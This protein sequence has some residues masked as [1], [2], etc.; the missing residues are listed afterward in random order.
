MVPQVTKEYWC[1]DLDSYDPYKCNALKN[2]GHWLDPSDNVPFQEYLQNWQPPGCMLHRYNSKDVSTCFNSRKVVLVG[3][4]TVRQIY[5]AIAR[6]L[7]AKAAR[8]ALQVAGKH[9]DLVFQSHNVDIIFVWDPYLNS[10]KLH[11]ELVSYRGSFNLLENDGLNKSQIASVVVIGGG[12]WDV[13][14]TGVDPVKHFAVSIDEIVSH[15]RQHLRDKTK[16]APQS[17]ANVPVDRDL[18]LLTPVQVPL[19]EA[20]SPVRAKAITPKKVNSM[21]DYLRRASGSSGH[22]VLWSYSTM[23]WQLKAAYEEGGLHV[24]D[25][26][27]NQQADILLNLRCNAKLDALGR[28]PFDRTCCSRYPPPNQVQWILLSCGLWAFPLLSLIVG[29]GKLLKAQ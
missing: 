28:Y 8:E 19:Y 18:L 5:W 7:D 14:Y 4:S 1:V 17:S 13:R 12:L 9:V 15:T 25:S 21:N 2:E 3:D 22:T 11:E 20:L 24:V 23:T 16:S 27:A 26:V 10:T 6:K 29:K